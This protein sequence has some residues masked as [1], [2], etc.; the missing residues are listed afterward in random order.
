MYI[1][2]DINIKRESQAL[3]STLPLLSI[4]TVVCTSSVGDF[5]GLITIWQQ[6]EGDACTVLFIST[7]LSLLFLWLFLLRS[8]SLM[9]FVNKV[10]LF[11]AHKIWMCDLLAP[12]CTPLIAAWH[13]EE[14][15][16]DPSDPEYDEAVMD[17][18]M[19][20]WIH[21][22]IDNFYAVV[23]WCHGYYCTSTAGMEWSWFESW[24]GAF[25][26][27]CTCGLAF[28]PQSEKMDDR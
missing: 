9:A 11:L 27:P 28:L 25:I 18:W 14:A 22:W 13:L 5:Y 20:G 23:W 12:W 19:D 24:Y 8:V 15:P 2:R 6:L 7:L 26:S 21:G 16:A 1:Y 4:L 17:G 10:S 3:N